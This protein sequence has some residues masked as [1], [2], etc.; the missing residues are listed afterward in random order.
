MI[1]A[2][3]EYSWFDIKPHSLH[4]ADAETFEVATIFHRKCIF[5]NTRMIP[6]DTRE[7]EIWDHKGLEEKQPYGC[8]EVTELWL[9]EKK[10]VCFRE[11]T[12]V[13]AMSFN[14]TPLSSLAFF[15]GKQI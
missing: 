8:K 4:K 14:T 2:T 11:L 5:Q 6:R 13:S 10:R 1:P 9:M 15:S 12:A 3:Q 7:Q